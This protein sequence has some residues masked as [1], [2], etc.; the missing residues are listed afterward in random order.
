MSD[1]ERDHA[2][3]KA[4]SDGESHIIDLL[5]EALDDL[6]GLMAQ[7]VILKDGQPDGLTP[8]GEGLETA[9]DRINEV[10]ESNE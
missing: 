7:E 5:T 2:I 4:Y 1:W 9:I 8:F 6:N 10:I 3:L